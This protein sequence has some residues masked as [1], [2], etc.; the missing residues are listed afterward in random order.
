MKALNNV[1]FF[2]A[3]ANLSEALGARL[4][5]LVSP[6]REE[7]GCLQYDIYRS[8]EDPD[9]WFVYEDWRFR[10][11]LEAHLQTPYVKARSFDFT[12]NHPDRRLLLW[13]T[14]SIIE[15]R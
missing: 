13:E 10:A 1:A 3:K 4:L 12:K 2:K 15:E 14:N 7:A 6:T 11:D 8:K 9:A 5:E